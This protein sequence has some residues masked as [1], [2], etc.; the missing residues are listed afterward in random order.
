[1]KSTKAARNGWCMGKPTH[2]H[3]KAIAGG[4]IPWLTPGKRSASWGGAKWGV[5]R[6]S[7]RSPPCIRMTRYDEVIY[8]FTAATSP[9]CSTFA[10]QYPMMRFAF[11]GLTTAH[12]LRRYSA[13]I[14]TYPSLSGLIR[15]YPSLS[16][17][18]RTYPS[19]SEL[20][21]AKLMPCRAPR[22]HLPRRI[23]RRNGN[24]KTQAPADAG[25]CVVS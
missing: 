11:M 3:D 21:P 16:E 12:R 20:I 8:V 24:K 5:K 4:D 14:R 13:I 2:L 9:R 25:A 10:R 19:L 18:I 6:T 17:L 1:M 22:A 15:I 7:E 23:T